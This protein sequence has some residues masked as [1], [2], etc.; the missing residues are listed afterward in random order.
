M[1]ELILSATNTPSKFSFKNA[2]LNK[3]SAKIAEQSAAMNSVYN[4]AKEGA[5]AVNKALAPLFG[6]LMASK[7]YK[8]DGFKSVADYAEQ[9]FGMSK[10]MAYMLARVGE[11]FYNTGAEGAKLAR[12]TLSTSKLA[13][14]TG[15]DK[16]VVGDAIKAGELSAET[17]LVACRDFATA[18]KKPGK[19]KVVP[20]FD[21]FTL[22]RKE[23]DLPKRSAIQKEDFKSAI[24]EARD[25]LFAEDSM[26]IVSVKLDGDKPSAKQHFILCGVDGG[27]LGYTEMWEYVPYVKPAL[28]GKKREAFDL[29]AYLAKLSP[30]DRMAL[31][32]SIDGSS[33]EDEET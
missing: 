22:P 33:D 26:T 16:K 7:C 3:I 11:A 27:V 17:P 6:E 9:T 10:S 19:E 24:L 28:K 18:H 4:A 14:L 2:Q 29:K 20:L 31:L 23:G 25:M 32:Q 13:E 30:E 12:E 1:N 8:D 21:L 5:E 15:T